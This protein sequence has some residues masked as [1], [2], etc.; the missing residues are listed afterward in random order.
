MIVL[1]DCLYKIIEL[2]K[3][4]KLSQKAFTDQLGLSKASFSE[5]KAGRSNSYMKYLPQ[6]AQILGTSVDSLLGAP[7]RPITEDEIKFALFGGHEGITDEMYQEV[8]TFARYVQERH[9]GK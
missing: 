5:W 2:M 4:Q 8:L 1:T 6:I 9:R 3:E 7:P